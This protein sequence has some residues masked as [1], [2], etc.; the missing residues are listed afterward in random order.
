MERQKGFILIILV[1]VAVFAWYVVFAESEHKLK[2]VF[3]N[4]GQGDAIFIETPSG[5]QV[6]I[7]GGAG[8][9]VLG[10]L[11]AVMPLYDRQID[12]VMATHTDADHIGGLTEVLRRYD[13][14][15]VIENGIVADTAIW[16]ELRA[17]IADEEA[18]RHVATAG[19][20]LIL[21]G[22][23]FIDILGPASGERDQP[24]SKANDVMI[25]SRLV[26]G[27]DEIL[28]AG[29]I[30]RDDE[31]RLALSGINLQSDILKVAHHGSKNSSTDLFL[32][33]VNPKVAVVSAGESNRYGHPHKE[34]LDRILKVG[35]ELF[36]T[37]RDGRLCFISD[38]R[39][40]QQCS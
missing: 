30:E 19:D 37:D 20:R 22:G 13:V 17:L 39:G 25:V 33:R 10:E 12:M 9:R 2:V 16:R 38:G 21:G 40:W 34:A 6:L 4:V 23:A 18:G 1:T 27:E 5:A 14:G 35:A 28:L 8:A 11:A 31:V 32:E 24:Q 36:R 29:D 26:Y 7:D 15:T 3:L